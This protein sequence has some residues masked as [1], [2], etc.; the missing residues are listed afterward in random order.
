MIKINEMNKQMSDFKRKKRVSHRIVGKNALVCKP[1]QYK[2][3]ID[4]DV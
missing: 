4:I 1:I 3:D 2:E